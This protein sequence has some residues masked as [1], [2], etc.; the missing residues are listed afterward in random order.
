MW[1]QLCIGISFGCLIT[2]GGLAVYFRNN[3]NRLH[4]LFPIGFGLAITGWLFAAAA[5]VLR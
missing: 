1:E 2:S 4:R 5:L 3:I